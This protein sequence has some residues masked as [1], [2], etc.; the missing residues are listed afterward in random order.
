MIFFAFP[1]P[2]D[3]EQADLEF[4]QR[5]G[6]LQLIH[7]AGSETDDSFRI[8]HTGPA[9]CHLCVSVPDLEQAVSR[10]KEMGTDIVEEG[11]NDQGYAVI[12][13]PDGYN[14]QLLYSKVDQS[15]A[16]KRQL[17]EMMTASSHSSH[18]R[19]SVLSGADFPPAG[20]DRQQ[21]LTSSLAAGMPD[22]SGFRGGSPNFEHPA[23]QDALR[24]ESQASSAL[25]DS[26][27]P[28]LSAQTFTEYATRTAVSSP[29]TSERLN[30]PITHLSALTASTSLSAL[31]SHRIERVRKTE[32]SPSTNSGIVRANAPT[33]IELPDRGTATMGAKFKS[34]A[35]VR[36]S[37]R[38][39]DTR[40]KKPDA[41]SST[42]SKQQPESSKTLSP[43]KKTTTTKTTTTTT[44]NGTGTKTRTA[45]LEAGRDGADRSNSTPNT[46]I[47]SSVSSAAISSAPTDAGGGGALPAKKQALK[48]L[49][50]RFAFGHSNGKP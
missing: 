4:G 36:D 45:A 23:W 42:E 6:L 24:E 10:M 41:G 5:R 13:D 29:A 14:I 1:Q 22:L 30:T 28:P 37:T 7:V 16:L 26:P 20:L 9:F 40:K 15:L 50:G 35:A 19:P 25:L 8:R 17:E 31:T 32:R 33:S 48:A 47:S 2:V 39:V 46:Q 38:A 44:S 43:A 3:Q 12:A 21:S 18:R 27:E 11:S 49:K 34:K